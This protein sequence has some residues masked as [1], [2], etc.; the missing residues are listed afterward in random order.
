MTVDIVRCIVQ[1]INVWESSGGLP[2]E[3]FKQNQELIS[4]LKRLKKHM[5]H[6]FLRTVP[7]GRDMVEL[8]QKIE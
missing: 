8:L 5:S 6:H 2:K 4:V 7:A 3:I 1:S